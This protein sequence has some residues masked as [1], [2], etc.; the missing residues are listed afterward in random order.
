MNLFLAQPVAYH[1]APAAVAVQ[2]PSVGITQQTLSRSLGGAQ[3]LSSY[4]KS[5]DSAF[6]SVRKYDTRI[7][8]DV[9]FI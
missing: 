2:A 4:S 6:S 3:S 8:N 1:A 7:T 5:E 9:S